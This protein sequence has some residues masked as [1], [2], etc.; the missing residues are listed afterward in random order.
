MYM[1]IVL[2]NTHDMVS[3]QHQVVVQDQHVYDSAQGD[4][5]Q[6]STTAQQVVLPTLSFAST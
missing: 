1:T 3:Q 5:P 6:Y 2:V 4:L